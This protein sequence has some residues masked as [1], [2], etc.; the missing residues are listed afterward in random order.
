MAAYSGGS[1]AGEEIAATIAV[2]DDR[3]QPVPQAGVTFYAVDDGVL[4]LTGFTRPEPADVFLAPA[5]NR[6]LTGL[7]LEQLLPVTK[8]NAEQVEHADRLKP[9]VFP[10]SLRQAYKPV[11]FDKYL[12]VAPGVVLI[13]A[14]GHTPG[15]QIIY[16]RRTDGREYLFIGDVA[17]H[18]RNIDLVRE[19]ARLVTWW[20]LREDRDAVMLQLAELNR[21]QRDEPDMLI[22]PGHDPAVLAGAIEAGHL[23]KEFK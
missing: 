17:W 12:A 13:R 6:V 3:G 21:L 8:L 1:G 4:A 2:T 7:N 11:S 14:A 18:K 19:R 9:S 23:S 22:M 20:F 10:E 5:A 15:S 16:V